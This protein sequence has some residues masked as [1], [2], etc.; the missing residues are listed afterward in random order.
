MASHDKWL[1]LGAG[2][3][4]LA[5]LMWY[6]D[7]L[8]KDA[9]NEFAKGIKLPDLPLAGGVNVTLPSV[10][11]TINVQA[12][13]MSGVY[14]GMTDLFKNAMNQA[15]DQTGLSSLE[16]LF[17]Q[18]L[19]NNK[20][21]GTPL[22]G[23][24]PVIPGGTPVTG[25][26]PKI[27]E[28]IKANTPTDPNRQPYENII[29]PLKSTSEGGSGIFVENGNNDYYVKDNSL[30]GGNS[31]MPAPVQNNK[32][33]ETIIPTIN[34]DTIA[35]YSKNQATYQYGESSI[36]P[37]TLTLTEH[38][39]KKTIFKENTDPA[40]GRIGVMLPTEVEVSEWY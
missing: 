26:M 35:Q 8:V 24:Y 17:Q 7:K 3:A 25:E 33:A 31:G 34:L 19:G 29:P 2:L 40:R 20:D 12:P 27:T 10:N 16:K 23:T 18:Y 9:S 22:G 13:D 39:V 14:T 5:A 15:K 6:G 36:I 32:P 37:K 4:A 38:K 30:Y 28:I 21:Q 1:W 11:P